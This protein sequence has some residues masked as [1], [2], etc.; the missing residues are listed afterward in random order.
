MLRETRALLLDA[1]E[2]LARGVPAGTFTVLAGASFKA[3]EREEWVE[4]I[5]V[6]E[7]LLRDLAVLAADPGAGVVNADIRPRLEPLAGPLGARAARALGR[8]D[9]VRSDLRVNVNGRLAA[10]RILLEVAR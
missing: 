7:I 1:L 5:G 8:L 10:E 2:A 9:S 3:R 4:A 6:L